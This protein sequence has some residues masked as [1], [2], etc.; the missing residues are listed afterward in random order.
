MTAFHQFRRGLGRFVA[1][2]FCC[3]AAAVPLRAE[4]LT[5]V[6]F[7]PAW[8]PQ[9][10]FAGFYVAQDQGYYTEA[11]LDVAILQGGP[12]RPVSQYLGR[13]EVDFAALFLSQAI[14]L[15]G[16]G[17]PV[18]NLAQL[19]Q[20]SSQLL[21]AHV[22][23]GIEGPADL[24]GRRVAVWPDF[25]AQPRALFRRYDIEPEIVEQG[26]SMGVFLHRGVDAAS[27][28]RYNEFQRLYL[29][30]YEPDEFVVIELAAHGVGF[31][32]DG[33]Y[34]LEHSLASRPEVAR[35]FVKASLLGWEYAFAN[36][37]EAIDSV[38]ARVREAGVV[39]SRAHQKRMLEV[40]RDV[41]FEDEGQRESVVLSRSDFDFVNEALIYSGDLSEPLDYESF[42][43]PVLTDD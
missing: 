33:I 22:D 41:Y 1:M 7:L 43:R 24:D 23:S 38:M 6:R 31:P 37:E 36:P 25:I 17:V 15:R 26:A 4:E 21:V 39:S 12:E 9:A 5:S 3:L 16:A 35:S 20:R 34:T 8:I 40:L 13:G 27:A 19:I 11:G 18:V 32:E 28:M 10:Q 2:C 29:S 42:H 30:G 14:E